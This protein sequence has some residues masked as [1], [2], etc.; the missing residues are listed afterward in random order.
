MA[1]AA[2]APGT[3]PG[4]CSLVGEFKFLS[5]S[6]DQVHCGVL[7]DQCGSTPRQHTASGLAG[8]VHV[9][10][11]AITLRINQ[12]IQTSD[13]QPVVAVSSAVPVVD[14]LP[15]GTYRLP[16]FAD[17][18]VASVSWTQSIPSLSDSLRCAF[19]G[20]IEHRQECVLADLDIEEREQVL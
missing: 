11:A 5:Q 12:R 7:Q 4:R 14:R 3:R 2:T 9:A 20:R 1:M 16:S 6:V 10:S 19:D 8:A 18:A 15:L 17:D 13:G